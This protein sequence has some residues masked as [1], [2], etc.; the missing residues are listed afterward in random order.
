MGPKAV[1]EKSKKYLPTVGFR[2]RIVQPAALSHLSRPSQRAEITPIFLISGQNSRDVS[3]YIYKL[4]CYLKQLCICCA[5][6]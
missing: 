6:C 4:L 2:T 5:I 1:L 3:R